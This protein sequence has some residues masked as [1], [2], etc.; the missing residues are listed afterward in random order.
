MDDIKSNGLNYPIVVYEGLI[1]DGRNRYRA[2]IEAGLTPR[3][4]QY[5]D[6]DPAGF[7]ISANIHR[8]HL[9]SKER[10]ELISK[11][12]KAKPEASDRQ[13]AATVSVHHGTVGVVRAG[14]ERRGEIS[15]VDTRIDTK[16]RKQPSSKETIAEAVRASQV[17]EVADSDS[18]KLEQWQKKRKRMLAQFE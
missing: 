2:C 11:L 9:T 16:G 12:L 4:V 8:R 13:I 18:A 7:V 17:N 5:C 10:R 6:S 3:F 15:H 14:L 1:L